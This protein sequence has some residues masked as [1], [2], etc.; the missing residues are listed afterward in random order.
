MRRKPSVLLISI[1]VHAIV[2]VLLATAPWWSPIT[3]W[4]MPRE[5]L[6]FTESPHLASLQDIELPRA[7][8]RA[9]RRM[10]LHPHPLPRRSSRRSSRRRASRRKR[11]GDGAAAG[12]PASGD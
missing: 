3:S 6:A 12:P 11:R 9:H 10:L 8:A 7:A 4:P 2:L 5:V 1:S